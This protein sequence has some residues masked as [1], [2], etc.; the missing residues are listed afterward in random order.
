MEKAI[1]IQEINLAQIEKG[2]IKTY[3]LALTEDAMG[4]PI[5][6]PVMIGKGMK[7]GPVLGITAAVHGNELNGINVIQRLFNNDLEVENMSG[8]VIGIPI[9]NIPSYIRQ[10][11]Y[12]KDGSDLNRIMPGKENGTVAETYA[13]RFKEKVLSHFDY[14]LDLHTASFGRVN[15]F[16]IRSDMSK[17][18]TKKLARLQN[19]EIILNTPPG[20]GTVRGAAEDLNIPA[21]TIEVGNPNLFQKKMIRSGLDGIHN[22]MC[23]LEMIDDEQ[24]I[25]DSKT[26]ECV[27]SQWLYTDL[28]GLLN[29]H[30]DL[31]D[32]VEKGQHIASLRDAFGNEIKKYLAPERGIVIGKS[33]NPVSPTGSRILH[34]G[35]IKD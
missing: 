7:D 30:V 3:W 34:L 20:D 19:A 14:L 21:I 32:I 28:G 26:I 6:M 17:S 23:H 5:K 2:T 24:E 31:K 12:F 15:S 27:S 22:V 33:V 9:V 35:R 25:D 13:H 1:D 4:V 10:E 29:V 16:Y 18:V 11:R 8:I